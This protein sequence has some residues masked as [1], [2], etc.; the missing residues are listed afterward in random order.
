MAKYNQNS[1]SGTVFHD[2][3]IPERGSF[4]AGYANLIELHGLKVVAPDTLCIIGTK[5][6]KY[7]D[8]VASHINYPNFS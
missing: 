7:M 6:K 2:F 8:G 3:S 1:R 5:H 4:L